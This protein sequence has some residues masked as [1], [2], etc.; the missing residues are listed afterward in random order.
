MS[1]GINVIVNFDFDDLGDLLKNRTFHDKDYPK[2]F[3]HQG[4]CEEL[5]A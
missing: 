5:E 4:V 2:S 3:H 1:E